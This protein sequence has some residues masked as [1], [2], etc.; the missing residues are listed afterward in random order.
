ME[1]NMT[2]IKRHTINIPSTKPQCDLMSVSFS[3]YTDGNEY[4]FYIVGKRLYSDT[5]I[6]SVK[7]PIPQLKELF[8]N[9]EDV[10]ERT[11][12]VTEGVILSKKITLSQLINGDWNLIVYVWDLIPTLVKSDP[13]VLVFFGTISEEKFEEVTLF[14][15]EVIKL[16]FENESNEPIK[17]APTEIEEAVE[18]TESK[19]KPDMVNHPP[20]YMHCSFECIEV[21]KALASSEQFFGY[22][23]LNALKYLWR[24]KFKNEREDVEKAR[25]Y[26]EKLK[27]CPAS[28]HTENIPITNF[29]NNLYNTAIGTF[30]GDR[31]E[32]N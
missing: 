5:S 19:E 29:L 27:E 2:L 3:L 14:I 7:I 23:A 13:Y 10:I 20:H 24:F 28:L 4:E 15:Q 21:M 30:E 8:I 32:R 6:F 1:N 12:E 31:E 25:W 16:Y 22:C 26:L 18:G 11:V 17:N 9:H